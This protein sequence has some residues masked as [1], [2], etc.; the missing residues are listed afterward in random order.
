L[1]HGIRSLPTGHKL[2]GGLDR[3]LGTLV[4]LVTNS[5]S[6]IHLAQVCDLQVAAAPCRCDTVPERSLGRQF[7]ISTIGVTIGNLVAPPVAGA[8][9]QRWGFRAPFIFGIIVTGFDLL[10][11]LFII[12]RHEAMKW[13]ADPMA[14]IVSDS[15][16]PEVAL[17]GVV[18]SGRG[19]RFTSL[20]PQSAAWVPS[21][22]LPT[23]ESEGSTEAEFDEKR[24]EG[25]LR[26][27][28]SQEIKQSRATLLP[29][30]VLLKLMKS[31]RATVCILLTLI[32]GLG[33]IAQETTVVLHMNRVWGLDSHQAGI[34][35][36]AAIVPT[37]FCEFGISS[38]SHPYGAFKPRGLQLGPFLVGW[39]IG[40]ARLRSDVLS[41]CFP[42]HG[43]GCSLLKAL[44]PR[45]LLSLQ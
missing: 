35:F 3:G 43:M 8:L 14:A 15:K 20:E 27:G 39:A 44:L 24:R 22:H 26:E 31:S 38:L 40:M 11:R 30:V 19:G 37:V 1:A 32:W 17:P 6:G 7:G 9:Y 36:I 42:Y 41:C 18:P 4:S 29:H 45:S 33:W 5:P 21:D 28:Q 12:E 34:A 23:A 10:A 13:D 16:D 25:N 2:S